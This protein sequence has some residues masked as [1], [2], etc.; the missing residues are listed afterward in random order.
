MEERKWKLGDDLSTCDSLLDGLTFGELILTVH[1]N[2]RKITPEAVRKELNEIMEGRLADMRFLLDNNMD[3]IMEA[4][5][6]GR[7]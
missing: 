1:C 4:A 2:C 7:A 5:G 3:A 6:K